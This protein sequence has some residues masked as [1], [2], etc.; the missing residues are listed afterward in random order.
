MNYAQSTHSKTPKN[1][2]DSFLQ[3][4]VYHVIKWLLI[5]AI[6]FFV[7]KI[8]SA[9]LRQKWSADYLARGDIYLEQKKYLSAIVEYQKAT[10]LSSDNT[11]VR[12]RNTL[13]DNAESD[14]TVL[15]D[16]YK[17]RNLSD[18]SAEF[19][20][21]KAEATNPAEAT[22]I[23][24]ELIEAGEYQLA[25]IPAKLATTIDSN[26]QPGWTYLAIANLDVTKNVEMSTE[27]RKQYLND[28]SAAKSHIIELP[29]L[30]R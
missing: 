15:E 23:S 16:F 7:L 25:I 29:D 19:T 30:L 28:L 20:K 4:A 9:P 12:D 27:A 26:Y 8:I 14:V 24:K 6:T 3:V 2:K 17:E 13:A 18:K 21:A 5:L 1:N 22:K 10:L 11:A